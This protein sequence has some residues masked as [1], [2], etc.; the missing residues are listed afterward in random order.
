MKEII[1]IR[2]AESIA[3]AG[4]RTTDIASITLSE[5]GIQQAIN[6][7]ESFTMTPELVIVS[8]YIRTQLTAAPLIRKQDIHNIQ[9][10]EE[11]K[12]FTYLDR[13]KWANTTAHERHAAA[14]VFWELCDPDYRDAEE[15]SF[16]DLLNRA[17]LTLEKLEACPENKIVVFSHGQFLLALRMHLIYGKT[18]DSK[19]IMSIFEDEFSDFPIFNTQ[20]FTL[21]D[22]MDTGVHTGPEDLMSK[23]DKEFFENRKK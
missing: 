9:I 6:L 10:W 21:A 14:R 4:G 11:V 18:H 17:K 23:E 2:H 12:E 19:H 13:V 22:L 20:Q 5:R 3:N 16:N 15:E 8:P 7:A 1:F